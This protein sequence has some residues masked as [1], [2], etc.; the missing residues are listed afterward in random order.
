MA[1][2]P[3]TLGINPWACTPGQISENF[4]NIIKEIVEGG[5]RVRRFRLA[6]KLHTGDDADAVILEFDGTNY[7]EGD[8]I[9]VFDHYSLTTDLSARGMFQGQA[10]MEGY[11]V[12]RDKPAVEGRLEGDILWMEMFAWGIEFTL[13]STFSANQATA[14]VDASWGQGVAPTSPLTVH[15]DQNNYS[16]AQIGDKGVA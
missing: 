4:Q 8:P 2:I 6:D 11:C 1:D 3:K 14:T 16:W 15:D 9:R 7:V 13:T 5:N 10:D 12:I